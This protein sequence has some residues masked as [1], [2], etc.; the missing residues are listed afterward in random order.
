MG[1]GRNL[2]LG[3]VITASDESVLSGAGDRCYCITEVDSA[4]N[5]ISIQEIL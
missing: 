5:P 2:D 1:G 4:D 3:W